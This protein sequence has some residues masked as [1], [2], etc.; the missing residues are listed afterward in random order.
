MISA[1]SVLPVPDGPAN[2]AT[3]Y[4]VFRSSGGPFGKINGAPVP[5]PPYV[6]SSVVGN[7]SRSGSISSRFAA[8]TSSNLSTPVSERPRTA[9]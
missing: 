2:S 7:A 4:D 5:T 1:A 9:L 6:D 8:T 3:S